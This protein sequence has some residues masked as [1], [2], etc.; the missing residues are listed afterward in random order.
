MD[1]NFQSQI[2]FRQMLI[3]HGYSGFHFQSHLVPFRFAVDLE[4]SRLR[5]APYQSA[6]NRDVLFIQPCHGPR[7]ELRTRKRRRWPGNFRILRKCQNCTPN[8]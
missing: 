3:P 1:L 7:K 2:T 6:R 4:R 8:E 5:R